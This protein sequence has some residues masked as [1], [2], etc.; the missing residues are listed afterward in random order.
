MMSHVE[1]HK[2][3]DSFTDVI[4]HGVPPRGKHKTAA[5]VQAYFDDS[6][7]HTSA[8][9]CVAAG[10]V[11]ETDEW[12]RFEREWVKARGP[13]SDFHA[14][15]FFQKD[16]NGKRRAPYDVLSDS[17]AFLQNL[18]AVIR[19][20]NIH[21]L[22]STIYPLDF[23]KF[24]LS[25]RRYLTGGTFNYYNGTSGKW[26]RSGKPSE[27][28]LLPFRHIITEVID[29]HKT[30]VIFTFDQD[31]VRR[32]F[33]TQLFSYTKT[34]PDN[35]EYAPFMENILLRDRAQTPGL[36]AADMLA[37]CCYRVGNGTA[38]EEVSQCLSALLPKGDLIYR[39]PEEL[40]R[41]L[42]SDEDIPLSVRALWEKS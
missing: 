42:L 6:G 37:Y 18:L 36:Q 27:P 10:F 13:V 2:R 22:C 33:M 25:Q 3:I 35:A 32:P 21:P 31:E 24:T 41:T 4:I 23:Q 14:K 15:V 29:R 40:M 1:I 34:L 16:Q 28:F 8:I 11:A 17:D 20:H 12:E 5:I 38:N 7:T 30:S 39:F 9:F 19:S 26:V